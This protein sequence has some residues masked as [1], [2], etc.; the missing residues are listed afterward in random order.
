MAMKQLS[1]LKG[2]KLY[3]HTSPSGKVYIGITGT[4]VYARWNKGLG[5]TGCIVFHRAIIK[6]GWDN[7]QHE[8]LFSDLTKERAIKLEIELIRH[9]KSLGISYNIDDGGSLHNQS[10]YCRRRSSENMIRLWKEKP[11]LLLNRTSRKGQRNSIEHIRKKSKPVIQF[12]LDGKYLTEYQSVTEAATSAG[13]T[14]KAIIHCCKGGYYSVTR[15][16]FININQ[17]GGY[18]WKY[19]EDMIW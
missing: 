11:E 7:I 3:R 9:Y 2:F 5:Y 8:V 13:S 10:E 4:S 19:K 14:N 16:K 15:G 1:K 18:I 17:S 12:S 6:Y